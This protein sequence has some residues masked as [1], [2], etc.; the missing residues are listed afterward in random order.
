[1]KL[2]DILD[3]HRECIR[4]SLEQRL[5]QLMK[6]YEELN[7]TKNKFLNFFKSNTP[8]DKYYTAEEND[9]RELADKLFLV[10][11]YKKAYDVYRNVASK[12]ENRN[13][14]I[15]CNIA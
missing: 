14:F 5:E 1:M 12:L 7:A 3:Y 4:K 10:E 13:N 15:E 2:Q 6:K 11:D 8:T 9:F